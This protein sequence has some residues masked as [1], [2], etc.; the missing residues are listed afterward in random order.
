MRIHYLQHVRFE[1][2]A[3]IQVWAEANAHEITGTHLYRGDNLPSPDLFDMLVV[4]GGPMNVY[5]EK[6]YPWLTAEK[7]FIAAA[8]EKDKAVIGICLGAQLIADVLGGK[9]FRN[10]HKEIG[11]FPVSVLPEAA[12]LPPLRGLPAEFMAFHWHGDTFSIP[13]GAVLLT[14]SK[15]CPTQA[16]SYNE[17]RV[18]GLQFHLES[19]PASV[20]ALI[21]N[22]SEE[23]VEGKYIQGADEILSRK[24]YFDDISKSML[25]LLDNV[26]GSSLE[27]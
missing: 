7:K 22:C 23:L 19:S 26:K 1:G 18:V 14:E 12:A 5:E 25:L 27:G 8:I 13:S 11:W 16:F 3:N 6:E 9:V 15:A 2:P 17:G 24:D 20:A 10:K 21:R 4:M